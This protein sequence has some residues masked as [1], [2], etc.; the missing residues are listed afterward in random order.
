MKNVSF[1]LA[2]FACLLFF[3]CGKTDSVAPDV[4]DAENEI[5]TEIKEEVVEPST[6][7]TEE[8]DTAIAEG[9]EEEEG[10]DVKEEDKTPE[11]PKDRE[12]E[13]IAESTEKP[14]KPSKPVTPPVKETPVPSAPKPEISA[15]TPSVPVNNEE[16]ETGPGPV[17]TTPPPPRPVSPP[18]PTP[19]ADPEPEPAPVKV[20]PDHS[21]WSSILSKH[22]SSSGVVDYKAMVGKR[23]AIQDYLDELASLPPKADWSR[24][25][26]MAYWI[27]LY[28]AATVKLIADNYGIKSI[29]ELDGGSPWK[30]KRV[31][32]G[33]KLL[34]LDEIENAILRPEFGD[35]RIHFAVN[36]AAKSC[37]PLMNKA[38]MPGSLDADLDRMTKKFVNNSKYNQIE[39]KKA[40]VSKIFEWYAVD[41]GDL[42]T[43]LNKYSSTQIKS[44][45]KIEY[46]EYDWSLNGN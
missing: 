18:V 20:K 36:C 39:S 44:G 4:R 19:V 31:K 17:P 28:N 34:T 40:K 24:N 37:P 26:K 1:A 38:W 22:V 9:N 3:S 6:I 29:T 13:P 11:K 23:G 30:K 21:G 2:V 35:A 16:P 15:P 33:A 8:D 12:T 27:N 14:G 7:E 41:F 46:N 43:Y 25:E 45:T 10:N 42:R 32:S 5:T